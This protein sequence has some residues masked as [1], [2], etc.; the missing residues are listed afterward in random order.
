M[1]KS[2]I[3]ETNPVNENPMNR[4]KDPPAVPIKLAKSKIN[5]SL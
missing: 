2:S 5:I 4:P 3:C 1:K